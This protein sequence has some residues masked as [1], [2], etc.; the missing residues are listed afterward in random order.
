MTAEASPEV[1]F[2]NIVREAH[3]TLVRIMAI[4]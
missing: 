3:V 4:L 1:K 2:Q